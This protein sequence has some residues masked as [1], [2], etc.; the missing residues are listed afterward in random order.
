MCIYLIYI[1]IK[2]DNEWIVL[3]GMWEQKKKT[4]EEVA[5]EVMKYKQSVNVSKLSRDNLCS[6]YIADQTVRY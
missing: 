3:M 6:T 1:K 2:N 5:Y 4:A